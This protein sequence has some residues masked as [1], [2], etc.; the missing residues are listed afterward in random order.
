M[1]SILAEGGEIVCGWCDGTR[2]YIFDMRS[3]RTGKSTRLS[4]AYSHVERLGDP[5][6]A[7]RY[8]SQ[9][10]NILWQELKRKP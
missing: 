4:V 10:L 8:V 6:V 5:A 3:L 2:S 1:L 7:E 9:Q